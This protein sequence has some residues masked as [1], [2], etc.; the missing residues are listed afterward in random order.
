V[1]WLILALILAVWIMLSVWDPQV[2]IAI[3]NFLAS[4]AKNMMTKPI[5]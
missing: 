1:K 5:K 3:T 2:I 4:L